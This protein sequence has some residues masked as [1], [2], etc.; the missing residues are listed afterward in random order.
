MTR[1]TLLSGQEIGLADLTPH[2]LDFIDDLKKMKDAGVSYF[3][4]NRSAVGPGSPALQG[5]SRINR[6][7]LVSPLYLV[8]RDIATR[9]G[10]EQGLVLAPEHEAQRSRAPG[11]FSMVSVTQAAELIGIS[12]AAV[13]KAIKNQRLSARKI[14]NVTVVDQASAVAFRDE[15]ARGGKSGTRRSSSDAPAAPLA[16]KQS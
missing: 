1:H 12:R 9:A 2:E 11:D 10:V 7:M 14:G 15:R 6:R 4:I 5:R 8:A 16:A 13:Y 3:E